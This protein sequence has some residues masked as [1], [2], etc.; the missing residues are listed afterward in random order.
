MLLPLLGCCLV[1]WNA[2]LLFSDSARNSSEFVGTHPRC[3]YLLLSA[4]EG[5]LVDEGASEVPF[6]LAD[7]GVDLGEEFLVEVNLR[8]LTD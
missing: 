4:I 5:L 2:F 3:L 6:A 8:G 1:D 7:R